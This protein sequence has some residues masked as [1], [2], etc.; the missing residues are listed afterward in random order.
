[1]ILHN[2]TVVPFDT[3]ADTLHRDV[4]DF[5]GGGVQHDVGNSEEG[6]DLEQRVI[7]DHWCTEQLEVVANQLQYA[8]NAW[9]LIYKQ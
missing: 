1:M 9:Q 5:V 4:E 8:K 7:P 6:V 3:V 2:S